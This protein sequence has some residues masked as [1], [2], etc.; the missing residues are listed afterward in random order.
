VQREIEAAGFTT[1]SLSPIPALTASLS[2]PR[3]VAIEY[4]LGRSL[5][6]P[7]DAAGQLAVLRAA[8]AAAET[9]SAAGSIHH[10]PF[11]WPDS[12]KTVRKQEVKP[13]PPIVSCLQRHPWQLRNL[14]SRTVPD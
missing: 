6:R 14:L 11:E 9:M 4:P 7:G 3:L 1:V 10:L 2:I 8:L 12:P 5:G 13:P